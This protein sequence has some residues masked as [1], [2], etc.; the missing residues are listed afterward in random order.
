MTHIPNP[1]D[2]LR[3]LMDQLIAVG[4]ALENAPDSAEDDFGQWHGA[5]GLDFSDARAVLASNV[6]SAVARKSITTELL[7][8]CDSV[9]RAW[10]GDGVTMAEAVDACLLAIAKA[11]GRSA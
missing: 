9:Q 5:E 7:E 11:T 4:I 3:D 6:D 2:A 10:V 8:A 1:L